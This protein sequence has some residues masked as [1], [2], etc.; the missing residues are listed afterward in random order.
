MCAAGSVMI[1]QN[2]LTLNIDG[3]SVLIVKEE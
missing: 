1:I 3:G 2:K